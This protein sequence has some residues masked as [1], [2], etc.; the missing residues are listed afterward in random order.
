MVRL[1]RI[2]QG[3]RRELETKF[4]V[5]FKTLA[6]SSGWEFLK[7]TAFR[8]IGDWFVTLD[9]SIYLDEVKARIG[10]KIKPITI[11]SLI[12]EIA[13]GRPLERH[14]LSL[15]ARGPHCLTLDYASEPLPPTGPVDLMLAHAKG[16]MAEA[17]KIAESF[18]LDDFYIFES[19][20][21]P[22]GDV[23]QNALMALLIAGDFVSARKLIEQSRRVGLSGFTRTSLDQIDSWIE[24]HA[25]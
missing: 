8:Q 11:D 4:L 5:A 21:R 9:P 18:S 12:T 20:E 23:S 14:P 19:Q 2:E 15:L 13:H 16:F 25:A 1:S 7:P 24:K 17:E 10:F 22:R 6:K 3:E